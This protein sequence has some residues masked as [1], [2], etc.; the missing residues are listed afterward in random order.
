MSECL[1]EICPLGKPNL[2]YAAV[3]CLQRFQVWPEERDR[4]DLQAMARHPVPTT[5]WRASET[6][7][8]LFVPLSA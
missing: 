7:P 2:T 5:V 6:M 3:H 8:N 4:R 1:C